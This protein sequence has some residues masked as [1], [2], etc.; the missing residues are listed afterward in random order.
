MRSLLVNQDSA[1][2]LA[3]ACLA[4]LMLAGGG[5]DAA[6]ALA[7]LV[8]G[9][10]AMIGAARLFTAS[11]HEV[12]PPW[13]VYA[14]AGMAVAVP[15]LQLLPL[16]PVVW[17]ALPGRALLRASLDLV[18]AG[19]SWRPLSLYPFETLAVLMTLVPAM[20]MLFLASSIRASGRVLLLI[21][22][23]MVALLALAIGTVQVSGAEGNIFRFYSPSSPILAGFQSNRSGQADIFL[24]AIVCVGGITRELYPKAAISGRKWRFLLLNGTAGLL[25]ALA[26]VLTRS[27]F[28]MVMVPVALLFQ[29]AFLRPA[30]GL[31]QR[32]FVGG[33]GLLLAVGGAGL[34]LISHIP[35]V[36]V[37]LVRFATSS[38]LRPEIWKDTLYLIAK[39][40]PWGTGMGTFEP[41]YQLDERL[42]M[43]T[44]RIVNRAHC[45]FLELYLEGGVPAVTILSL[46][47][48][49]VMVSAVKALRQTSAPGRWQVWCAVWGLFLIGAHSLFDYP[50]R[51]MSLEAIFAVLVAIIL[52]GA[53]QN[54]SRSKMEVHA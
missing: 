26:V 22:I 29:M 49:I 11:R 44:F 20:I 47:A 35:K 50:L 19:D 52:C 14:V 8:Q 45:D 6:P 10:V 34:A 25:F 28:G 48:I 41:V 7:G 39:Y 53:R 9:I 15:V 40:S 43:L 30:L 18:Q 17:H 4:V 31:S 51:S 38:E 36:S 21:L 12:S 32:A 2:F 46:M 1:T 42:E 33:A 23:V 24:I 54:I 16:P 37:S 27:R 5:G 13:T 3:V